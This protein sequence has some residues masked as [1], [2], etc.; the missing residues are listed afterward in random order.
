MIDD[1]RADFDLLA[2]AVVSIITVIIILI[3]KE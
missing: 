2:C 1:G 3:F